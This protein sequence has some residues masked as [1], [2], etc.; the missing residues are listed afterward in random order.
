MSWAEEG[1]AIMGDRKRVL[2]WEK[3][4]KIV[5]YFTTPA[6]ETVSQT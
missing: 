5:N 4:L 3:R 6:E 1:L 2:W